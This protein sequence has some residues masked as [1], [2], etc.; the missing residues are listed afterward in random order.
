MVHFRNDSWGG[1]AD[2]LKVATSPHCDTGTGGQVSVL[3]PIAWL[4]Y[5]TDPQVGACP[6]DGGHGRVPPR[7]VKIP[8]I[9][10]KCKF[11]SG[12]PMVREMWGRW[13]EFRNTIISSELLLCLSLCG[14]FVCLREWEVG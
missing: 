5:P 11:L 8:R 4:A 6:T 7:F 1:W 14:M 3:T 12:Q 10:A 9:L 2:S 13:G